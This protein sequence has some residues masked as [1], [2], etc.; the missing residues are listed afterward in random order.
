MQQRKLAER[1]EAK[2][3]A[4]RGPQEARML[5]EL[6]TRMTQVRALRRPQEGDGDCGRGAVGAGGGRGWREGS[7]RQTL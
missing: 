3:R 5:S 6:R 2:F 7:Y 1:R 4:E